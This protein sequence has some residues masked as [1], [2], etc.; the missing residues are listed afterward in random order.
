MAHARQETVFGAIGTLQF[1][2][3]LLQ[4][5]LETLALGDVSGGGEDALQLSRLVVEGGGVVADYRLE[6]VLGPDRQFVIGDPA[7]AKDYPDRVFRAE[8]I[9]EVP[10]KGRAD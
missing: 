4:R 5:S 7:V 6:A 3:L 10:L 1:H 8:R 2:I 9:R